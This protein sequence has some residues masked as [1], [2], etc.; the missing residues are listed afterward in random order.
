MTA[1]DIEVPGPIERL[2]DQVVRG[3]IGFEL[4]IETGRQLA[5]SGT[6]SIDDVGDV[7][8]LAHQLARTGNWRFGVLLSMIL[9]SAA[10]ALVQ[11]APGDADAAKLADHLDGDWIE[12]AGMALWQVPD[13]RVYA[14]GMQVGQAVLARAR[15]RKNAELESFALHAL[16]TLNLDPWFAN[17]GSQTYQNERD[18]WLRRGA[19]GESWD[20]EY[21]VLREPAPLPEPMQ[22]LD[23]AEKYYRA[24]IAVRSGEL[25]ARSLKALAQVIR[26][27]SLVD[28]ADR[29]ADVDATA[30][31]AIALLDPEKH[32]ALIAELFSYQ[33]KGATPE[34]LATIDALLRESPDAF[35]RRIGED[36]MLAVYLYIAIGLTHVAPDRALALVERRAPLFT[37]LADERR[38]ANWYTIQLLALIAAAPNKD[39]WEPR[40]GP[41]PKDAV[42]TMLAASLERG[43][44][45]RWSELPLAAEFVRLA[46]HTTQSDEEL[47]GVKLL[48]QAKEVA[49]LSLAPFAD[50]IAHL[51]AS[52]LINCGSNA[53]HAGDLAEAAAHYAHALDGSF[54]V[55]ALDQASQAM[56]RLADVA[57]RADARSAPAVLETL[58]R[59]AMSLVTLLGDDGMAGVRRICERT[60]GAL[61]SG[62]FDPK[63]LAGLWQ[64][65][66]GL[67]FGAFLTSGAAPRFTPPDDAEPLLAQIAALRAAAAAEPTPGGV[68]QGALASETLLLSPYS[69]ASI[70]LEGRSARER[71][72]NLELEYEAALDRRLRELAGDAGAQLITPAELREAI[73]PNTVLL[74]L[75][76]V[77][78]KDGTSALLYGV[79]T[80]ED[81]T[82]AMLPLDRAP[83]TIIADGVS[84]SISQLSEMVGAV[85]RSVQEEPAASAAI[86]AA[87]VEDLKYTG[88]TLLAP[89]WE[90]LT[91]LRQS[92]KRRLCIVPHGPLHYLPFHLLTIEGKP[93]VDHWSVSYLPNT[94]LLL[95]NRGPQS[96]RRHRVA[97]PVALGVSFR[98]SLAPIP[99]A[100]DEVQQ[101]LSAGK[102]KGL[103]EQ[104]VTEKAVLDALRGSRAVHVATHG[105]LQSGAAAF[106]RILVTPDG[107][108]DGML[109]AH[110]L[111]GLDGR[112]LGLVTLSA[113]ETALGRFDAGDN[114]RGLSA[115]LFL[116]GA[117]TVVG[118]LWEVETKTTSTFF[119]AMYRAIA[120]GASRIDAFG[121]AQAETRRA[122]PQYRD[123]GAFYFSGTWA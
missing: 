19:S 7:A 10:A 88:E 87:G 14:E 21:D 75:L 62:P 113:C 76:E 67:Q 39:A 37:Q 5:A 56:L 38:R 122:H 49:P 112:G 16:G 70:R 31:E 114:L 118:T 123:W 84:I 33:A 97:G 48:D 54:A 35:V 79:W 25:R 18:E 23:I 27:R 111:L 1:T 57:D 59:H 72:A 11:R 110:E 50:A 83:G 17:R 119:S 71:L 9:R 12:I 15:A 108:S 94:R 26:S 80:R 6:L 34:T 103:I 8:P 63:V 40:D 66:K 2:L 52:F 89:V 53:F 68:L 28:D 98:G 73:E 93:L 29:D 120:G 91:T 102:G 77:S 116:A 55:R 86:G 20:G 43:Q 65:A 95:A 115:N 101:I 51:R 82:F 46:R 74:D 81:V 96:I 104:Q 36:A 41:P 107:T 78:S 90:T 100:I 22:A 60:I 30:G 109:H 45:E 105:E 44:R 99:E 4:A 69:R 121:A 106:Q 13:A 58:A 32:P 117:E 92:G 24:A 3:E 61:S 42:R 85:R 47:L 64:V